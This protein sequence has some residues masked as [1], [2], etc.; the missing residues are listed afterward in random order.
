MTGWEAALLG[1]VQGLTEFLPVSSSGHLVLAKAIFGVEESGIAFEIFVHFGTLLAVLTVFKQD[2][3]NILKESKSLARR[4]KQDQSDQSLSE[5]GD[6][7][8]LLI[9][10]IIGTAP[11]ALLGYLYKDVFES[12]FSDPV[13]VCGMLIITGVILLITKFAKQGQSLNYRNSFIIGLA[14][15]GAFFPGISRSGTTISA[16]LLFGL[17]PVESARFSFLLA[18]PLIAGVTVIKSAELI[19]SPPSTS[20]LFSLM[21]GCF[22]AFLSGLLAIKWLLG[23][24]Q[25]SRI[26]RFAYYCFAIGIIGLII[27]RLQVA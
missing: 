16:G 21:L 4:H 5:S 2:I 3:W 7:S 15:V 14:Q 9:F 18:V 27:Y 12:F 10:L 8:R 24:V 26:D 11:A 19:M 23:I 6:G 1:I 22:F 13:F 20:E 25:R 17:K